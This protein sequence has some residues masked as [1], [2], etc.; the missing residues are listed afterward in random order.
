MGKI[1]LSE[2]ASLDG[3]VQD[4]TGDEGFAFGGWF[5][6]ITGVD[7]QAWSQAGLDEAQATTAYLLGRLSDDWFAARWLTRSG[8]WADRLNSM[9]KY[10]FSST[11]QAAK[12]TN[13]TVLSGDL[14]DDVTRLKRELDGD[15]VV[16]GSTRLAQSLW[17]ADLIDELR[18][19]LFPAVAGGGRR[20]FEEGINRRA[21][22]L[23]SV[24]RLG[25]SIAFL[26]YV[27]RGGQ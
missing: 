3:V 12:W 26:T 25:D 18:L 8:V 22:R 5:N 1:I 7:R 13:S 14:V 2:N 11:L 24:S 16:I 4:P 19:K 20:L 23:V 10:V 6:D 9:P 17:S 27:R 15:L 21:M